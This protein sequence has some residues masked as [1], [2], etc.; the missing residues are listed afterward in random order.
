MS[1]NDPVKVADAL[2]SDELRE[3][4][5]I[6]R[7]KERDRYAQVF[8]K[9]VARKKFADIAAAFDEAGLWYSKIY[10]FDDVADDPQA[11]AVDAFTE[12]DIRGEKAVL[13]NHPVKYDDQTLPLRIRAFGIG[14]N[15]RETL[16]ELGYSKEKIDDYLKRGIV[17]EGAKPAA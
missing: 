15:T 12:I 14:E 13:V 6:D 11:K 10:D 3:I 1:V 17:G 9:V 16:A 2:G 8:A 5:H 4:A 7:F